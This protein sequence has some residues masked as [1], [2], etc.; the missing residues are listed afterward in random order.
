MKKNMGYTDKIIRILLAFVVVVLY[1]T[2][3]LT[4]TAAIV[5]GI[6]ALV[7][8]ATSFI[9]FCPIYALL[10]IRTNKSTTK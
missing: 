5:S 3:V 10:G 2:K 6:I 9:N 7:L 8:L 1:Y 4:G